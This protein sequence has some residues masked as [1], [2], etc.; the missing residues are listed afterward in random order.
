[1][2]PNNINFSAQ[3]SDPG[4]TPQVD[5]H[6]SRKELVKGHSAAGHEFLALQLDA[7]G[8]AVATK[9]ACNETATEMSHVLVALREA[10]G[11]NAPTSGIRISFGRTTLKEDVDVFLSTLRGITMESNRSAQR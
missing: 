6:S 11:T 7:K 1:R 8:F 4:S 9:S 3:N 10:D 2:L 5:Y